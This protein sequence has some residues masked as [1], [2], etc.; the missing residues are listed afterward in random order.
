M[1][2]LELGRYGIIKGGGTLKGGGDA[3]GRKY[4]GA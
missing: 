1:G 2:N 4:T 3:P